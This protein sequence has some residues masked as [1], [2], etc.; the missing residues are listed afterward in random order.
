MT[1][2][3]QKRHEKLSQAVINAYN[4][5]DSNQDKSKDDI[6]FSK[7]QAARERCEAFE[8]KYF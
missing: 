4:K 3:Q 6:L 1:Y 5:W 7:L 2:V 8:D